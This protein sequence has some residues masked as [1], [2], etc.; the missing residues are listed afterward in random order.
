M[1]IWVNIDLIDRNST[2]GYN[3]LFSKIKWA[4]FPIVYYDT[5]D[6]VLSFTKNVSDYPI[7]MQ[8]W[9]FDINSIMFRGYYDLFIYWNPFSSLSDASWI[10]WFL[11]WLYNFSGDTPDWTEYLYNINHNFL[12]SDVESMSFSKIKTKFVWW[13][14]LTRLSNNFNVSWDIYVSMILHIYRDWN[15]IDLWTITAGW[16]IDVNASA[17]TS[18]PPKVLYFWEENIS[19]NFEKN[20]SIIV[21]LN[22]VSN[23]TQNWTPSWGG[24]SAITFKQ[25]VSFWTTWSSWI[26]SFSNSIPFLEFI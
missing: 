18:I 17:Y 20:D 1:A 5:N 13:C 11:F 9:W 25:E 14:N 21:E 3:N 12:V 10:S 6:N 22:I 7:I 15:I 19:W 2:S 26:I 4:F 23:F 8:V 24:A 16:S